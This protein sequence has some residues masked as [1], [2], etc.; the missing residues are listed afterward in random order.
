[1]SGKFFY[2][3]QNFL[4]Y[5]GPLVDNPD[6][7]LPQLNKGKGSLLYNEY[8]VYDRGQVK[9]KYLVEVELKPK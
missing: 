3:S 7:L 1:M 2:L 6:L 8:I 5:S 4:F 9:M